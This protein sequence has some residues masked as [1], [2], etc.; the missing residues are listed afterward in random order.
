[1]KKYLSRFVVH[2]N[3]SSIF[4][5]RNTQNSYQFVNKI[6]SKKDFL[7]Q[8][9]DAEAYVEEELL[10][11]ESFKLHYFTKSQNRTFFV[12]KCDESLLPYMNEFL[13]KCHKLT[14]EEN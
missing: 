14:A 3:R 6:P 8:M 7:S 5:Q 12:Q 11:Y 1:M 9:L 10:E 2:I 4:S 13:Q